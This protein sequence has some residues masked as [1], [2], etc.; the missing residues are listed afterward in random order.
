MLGN[1]YNRLNNYSKERFLGRFLLISEKLIGFILTAYIANKI[2]YSDIGFWSQI[3]YFAGL[4]NS[5]A[6]LNISNGIISIVPR[7]KNNIEKSELIFKSGLL[8]SFIGFTTGLFLFLIKGEISNLFFDEIINFKILFIILLIGF[9]E[10]IL[11]FI[12]FSF[13]SVNN[14][15][16]SNYILTLKIL[17]RIFVFIGA[18]NKNVNLMIYIYAATCLFSLLSIL[19]KL[20]LSKKNNILFLIKQRKNNMSLLGPRPYLKSLFIISKK[21]I[22]ATFTASLFFF[23]ARSIILSQIGLRGVGEFSLAISAGAIVMFLTNFIGFTFYPYISN[24]AIDEKKIA[25]QKTNELCLR[26]IYFS[27]LISLS[28]VILKIIFNNRLNFY[29][30]TINSLDLILAF[31]GYGFLSAYQISQPFAF[32]LTDNIKVVQIELISFAIAFGLFG[33]IFL[34]AGF[35]IHIIMFAFCFYTLGNYLQANYRNLEILSQKIN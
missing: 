19:L 28:L 15:N 29:P 11:E 21:S 17:P 3:I 14:F 6:G 7:I 26:I 8:L 27:I 16:F 1:I 31:L 23:F 24:L 2:S 22:F 34:G 32:A 25:F 10:M 9:C 5:L 33:F 18:Y 13:R 20:Y 12:L 35:S 4:Y 30:F